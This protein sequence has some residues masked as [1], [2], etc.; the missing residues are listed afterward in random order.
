MRA[1]IGVTQLGFSLIV[2][3]EKAIFSG[4]HRAVILLWHTTALFGDP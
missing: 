3:N 2:W 4:G 1:K